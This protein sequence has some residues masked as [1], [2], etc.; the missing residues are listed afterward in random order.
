VK[1]QS[2]AHQLHHQLLRWLDSHTRGVG[3]LSGR[4]RGVVDRTRVWGLARVADPLVISDAVSALDR[5]TLRSSSRGRPNTGVS[6]R[7][8]LQ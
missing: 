4:V 6:F 1:V 3:L 5:S 7:D 2:V 8:R